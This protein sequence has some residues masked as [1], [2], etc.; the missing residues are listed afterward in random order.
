MA[1]PRDTIHSSRFVAV[2]AF[3]LSASALILT[4][5]GLFEWD[6]PLTRFIRSLNDVHRDHLATPWLAQLSDFGDLLGSGE[7]LVIL[8]LVLLAVGYGLKA[9]QWKEAGWQSLIAHGLAALSV[10]ILK[11]MIGRPRPK[12]MH[13]GNLEFSPASGNGWDSFPSGHASAAFAVATVL[14]IKFPRMKWPILA[15]AAVIA[16]SRIVRGSHY[17]TDAAGGAALGCVMGMIAAHPWRE[18][19]ASIGTAVCRMTPFF[20]AMLAFVWTIVHLPSE[21][22]PFQQLVW[23]GLFLTLAGLVGHVMLMVQSLSWRPAWLT[24]SLTR[25]LVG[26]GLGMTTGSLLVTAVVLLVCA[27][28][29]LN[30]LPGQIEPMT[31][32]PVGLWAAIAEGLF[33][34]AMLLV[35]GASYALKGIVP[36]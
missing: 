31:E 32:G 17:L 30:D 21:A 24:G 26:L 22:W 33:V 3:L 10:N 35:L 12:F 20:V 8:S 34:A 19:R 6:V 7:S 14:A 5:A 25:V 2:A 18:W 4:F 23:G 15:V 27:A 1:L 28:Y 11:H 13:A 29:W 16:A 36:M 9:S